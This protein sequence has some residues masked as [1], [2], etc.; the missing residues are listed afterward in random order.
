MAMLAIEWL[1]MPRWLL[2]AGVAQGVG[3]WRIL[4]KHQ[5]MLAQVSASRKSK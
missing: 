1:I 4:S 2:V 5:A 3:E